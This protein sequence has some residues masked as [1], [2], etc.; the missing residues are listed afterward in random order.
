VILVLIPGNTDTGLERRELLTIW[1]DADDGA[2]V[3]EWC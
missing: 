2:C 3:G 1:G